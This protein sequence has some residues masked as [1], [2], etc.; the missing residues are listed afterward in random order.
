MPPP[1]FAMPRLD[2]PLSGG[3]VA[4]P[5]TGADGWS[6]GLPV[7][8]SD[9]HPQTVLP[10]LGGTASVGLAPIVRIT[11]AYPIE[12]R[13]KKQEG[14]VKME[15]T[16]QEDGTVAD[17]KVRE[18]SPSGIFD[19]AAVAAIGQWKFRPAMQNGK[20]VRKRAVQTLNFALNH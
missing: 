4:A 6:L 9:T 2:L 1:A 8:D 16:V 18:A 13:R 19:Q 14:W 3:P 20:A 12:A 10:T 15:F 17:I 7:L 11:P 5:V